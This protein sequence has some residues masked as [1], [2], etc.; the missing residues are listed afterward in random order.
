LLVEI[1]TLFTMLEEAEEL[2]EI[3][4]LLNSCNKLV[5]YAFL[6]VLCVDIRFA[7]QSLHTSTFFQHFESKIWN[8]HL[9]PILVFIYPH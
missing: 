4:C 8:L 7:F 9:C 2:E 5:R 1:G 3:F 6:P